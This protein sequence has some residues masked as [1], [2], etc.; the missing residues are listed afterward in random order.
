MSQKSMNPSTIVLFWI[1]VWE[2]D[3]LHITRAQII[4]AKHRST[5]TMFHSICTILQ[6]IILI[7]AIWI[8]NKYHIACGEPV[9]PFD[10]FTSLLVI[11]QNDQLQIC[12]VE[13]K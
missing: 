10:N 9:Y 6:I 1:N 4:S 12:F 3:S 7:L 13:Q 8:L 2:V 5:A 11:D